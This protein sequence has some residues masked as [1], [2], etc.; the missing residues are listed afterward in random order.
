MQ[1][2]AKAGDGETIINWMLQ[3][4]EATVLQRRPRERER[5]Q[6]A[7]FCTWLFKHKTQ[8][9]KVHPR[10]VVAAAKCVCTGKW[11]AA[12]QKSVGSGAHRLPSLIARA[13]TATRGF[14]FDGIAVSAALVSRKMYHEVQ[15]PDPWPPIMVV[16]WPTSRSSR[17]S[18]V[19]RWNWVVGS[20]MAHDRHEWNA[21]AAAL[22]KKAGPGEK[23]NLGLRHAITV[24]GN[25][26][27]EIK[28]S[29]SAAT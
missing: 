18:A 24:A 2:A 23:R 12:H 26:W 13:S 16:M 3:N 10:S 19:P 22:E 4:N 21:P 1:D 28:R 20:L 17:H 8:R 29:G 15:R 14:S 5:D 25:T 11:L 6:P 9:F 27:K 7:G